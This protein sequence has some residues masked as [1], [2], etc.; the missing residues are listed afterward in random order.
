MLTR[1][2]IRT[3]ASDGT[4][5][6]GSHTEK[7]TSLRLDHL[8]YSLEADVE[9]PSLSSFFVSVYCLLGF[10]VADVLSWCDFMSLSRALYHLDVLRSMNAWGSHRQKIPREASCNKRGDGHTFVSLL[11]PV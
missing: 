4:C 3:V 6:L 10:T 5:D 8:T 9:E 11:I 1:K 2:K 7:V